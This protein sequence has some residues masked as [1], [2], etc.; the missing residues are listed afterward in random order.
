[1]SFTPWSPRAPRRTSPNSVGT[2][3]LVL[4]I[5]GVISAGAGHALL[6]NIALVHTLVLMSLV[7]PIGSISGCHVN[8]AVTLALLTIRK[9][10]GRDAGIYIVCQV[11]GAVLAGLAVHE[12]FKL[13]GSVVDYGTPSVA[14]AYLHGGSAFLALIVEA[15]GALLLM[16][17]VMGTAVNPAAS[18]GVAGFAIG[19]ALG[20]GV[21]I[22]GPV[23][24]ASFNP[25]RWFG[26]AL[27]SG[28]FTDG[29]LYVLGPSS[30]RPPPRGCTASSW[31][32]TSGHC[33]RSRTRAGSPPSRRSPTQAELKEPPV[34]VL[35]VSD[36]LRSLFLILV[37]T[38]FILL[39]GC[40]LLDLIRGNHSGWAIVGWMVVILVIPIIGPMIYFALRKPTRNEVDEKYLADRELQ[41]AAAA[42]PVGGP[43]LGPY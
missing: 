22:F 27:I 5:C 23:T 40:A 2:F 34:Y 15:L 6:T 38:P 32:S 31:S 37:A 39:W 9:I 8:P 16:W 19:G 12:F 14:N 13:T 36:F 10:S 1:V 11:A 28:E 35:A 42:R 29:W 41:R 20:V 25:A 26:P 33:R 18:K 4:G 17:A 43:G 21:L 3:F 24:G 30:A 7:Y